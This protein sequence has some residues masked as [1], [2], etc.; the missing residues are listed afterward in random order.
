MQGARTAAY[1]ARQALQQYGAPGSNALIG[2]MYAYVAYTIVLL[3]EYFC[4]GIPLTTVNFQSDPIYSPGLTTTEL[5]TR[6]DALFDTAI[7]LSGDS[8]KYINLARVGKGRALL[9]LGK[10]P[11]AAAAVAAVPQNFA[12]NVDFSATVQVT[13]NGVG[14][15][16]QNMLGPPPLGLGTVMVVDNEG[17]RGL[18]WSTDPR[19]PIDPTGAYNFGLGPFPTK[20]PQN[21]SPIRLADWNEAQLITAEASLK[22]GTSNW[23]TILNGLR[24][25]CTTASGCTMVPGITGGTT[26]LPPLV[27]SLTPVKRLTQ[28]MSERAYWMY[29]TGHRQ[30]DLRRMMHLY[31]VDDVYPTGTYASAAYGG[32]STI[33]GSDVVALPGRSEQQFNPKYKGCFDRNP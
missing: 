11:E 13:I 1:Q 25:N 23:L 12:F 17:G 9:G 5:F 30:G 6:A 32:K 28:L 21:N 29:A 3:A 20:Y 14:F 27:D 26:Q 4:N 15:Y 33:Y 2:R 7:T 24:A 10:L 18:P 16:M 19:I 22:A 31:D 8:S